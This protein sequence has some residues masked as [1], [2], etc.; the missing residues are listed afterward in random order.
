MD[1]KR[2]RIQEFLGG[3]GKEDGKVNLEQGSPAWEGSLPCGLVSVGRWAAFPPT[4]A[5]PREGAEAVRLVELR[6]LGQVNARRR[7]WL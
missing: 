3:G 7:D 2:R 4:L 5:P 6:L 1:S